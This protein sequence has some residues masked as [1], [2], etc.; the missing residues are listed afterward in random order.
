MATILP[1]DGSSL[2]NNFDGTAI[3]QSMG[4]IAKES[5]QN[6]YFDI[7]ILD[8]MTGKRIKKLVKGNRSIDFEELKWLQ[9]GLSWSPDNKSIVFAAKAGKGD[10]LH[11]IDVETKKSQKYEIDIDGVFSAA[12][13]PKGNEIA[14]VGQSGKLS[15]IHI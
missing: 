10:V 14:F 13:S 9:P 8:A 11:V 15:L 3:S 2:W 7:H 1:G 4:S 12:W 6:G 5:L